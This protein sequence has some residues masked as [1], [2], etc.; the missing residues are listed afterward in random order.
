M[1]K[2]FQLSVSVNFTLWVTCLDPF[3]YM[4]PKLSIQS[5][6]H[7]SHVLQLA[8]Y[9]ESGLEKLNLGEAGTGF[10]SQQLS[11]LAN[12]GSFSPF[13]DYL[14]LC[15]AIFWVLATWFYICVFS[16]HLFFFPPMGF[17]LTS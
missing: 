17:C 14:L 13:M 4:L 16:K 5:I 15:D 9:L 10:A 3:P 12:G 1:N 11:Q 8:Q 7:A 6:T 2:L